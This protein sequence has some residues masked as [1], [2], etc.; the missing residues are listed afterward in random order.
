MEAIKVRLRE[1]VDFR[2]REPE[3]L[4]LVL[5]LLSEIRFLVGVVL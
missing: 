4:Q 5:I 1:T 2:V 3:D